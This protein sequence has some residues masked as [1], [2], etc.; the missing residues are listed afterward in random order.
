MQR[1]HSLAGQCGGGGGY[2]T[3]MVDDYRMADGIDA[4][5]AGATGQLGELAW[6]QRHMPG[7]IEFLKLFDHHA[8]CRHIDAQSQ[9]SVAK[10]IFTRPSSNSRSTIC[11]NRATMPA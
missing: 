8:S 5:S 7:A 6:R 3:V 1:V 9:L 4:T 11:R 10:T 2:K